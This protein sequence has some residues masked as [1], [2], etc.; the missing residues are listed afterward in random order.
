M[1]VGAG[2]KRLKHGWI[3]AQVRHDAELD[4]RIIRGKD[5]EVFAARDKRSAN[6]FSALLTNGDRLKVRIV[7]LHPPGCCPSLAVMRM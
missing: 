6:F 4:L 2:V 1:N 5:F 7:G 3:F